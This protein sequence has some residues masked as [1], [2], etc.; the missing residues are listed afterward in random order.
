[1]EYFKNG[2]DVK[3]FSRAYKNY[4]DDIIAEYFPIV[5]AALLILIGGKFTWKLVKKIKGK[6]PGLED[7]EI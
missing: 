6:N 5:G 7:G 3:Y 1:M 4:R 2:N